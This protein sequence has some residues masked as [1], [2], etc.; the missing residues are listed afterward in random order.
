MGLRKGIAAT[1]IG[2]GRNTS[3]I[4]LRY[5]GAES[6]CSA[7][8]EHAPTSTSQSRLR[9]C[10]VRN[11]TSLTA[12]VIAMRRRFVSRKHCAR[13]FHE[14]SAAESL[15]PRV[16]VRRI[17][18]LRLHTVCHPNGVRRSCNLTRTRDNEALVPRTQMSSFARRVQRRFANTRTAKSWQRTPHLVRSYAPEPNALHAISS[19]DSRSSRRLTKLS[20]IAP[21][22]N[23][24]SANFPAKALSCTH[25]IP[26]T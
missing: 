16:L 8:S 17:A 6:N 15:T 2:F 20:I 24:E 18:R 7:P 19:V 4:Q 21:Q 25:R 26:R 5:S 22:I 11:S 23:P 9:H 1:F 13:V 12:T 3:F 10:T 14:S